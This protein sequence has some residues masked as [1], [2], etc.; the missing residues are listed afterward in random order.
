MEQVRKG[1]IALALF[2]MKTREE[3][4][5]L[6]PRKIKS[7]LANVSR[8]TGVPVGELREFAREI[9]EELFH[10]CFNWRNE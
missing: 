5:R 6:L 8:K 3:G 9:A 10:E 2:K 1:E 4:V 7:D